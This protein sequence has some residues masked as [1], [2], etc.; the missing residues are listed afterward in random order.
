M[1]LIVTECAND[2]GEYYTLINPHNNSHCHSMSMKE[3]KKIQNCFDDMIQGKPIHKV[4]RSIRNRA[5]RLYS[6]IKVN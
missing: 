2:K 1:K 6:G 3:I 5:L 4:N